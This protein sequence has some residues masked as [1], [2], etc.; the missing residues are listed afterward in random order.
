[1][2]EETPYSEIP[3]PS[4]RSLWIMGIIILVPCAV[5]FIAK[6]Y[7]LIKLLIND[8]GHYVTAYYTP[9]VNYVLASIGFACL[10]GWAVLGG[11]FRDVERPKMQMLE[12]EER[13][14]RHS[15]PNKFPKAS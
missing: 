12:D 13:L 7:Q 8:A 11:M 9:A 5:G 1:M 14:E 3:K 4:N 15:Y 10:F 2:S 6:F